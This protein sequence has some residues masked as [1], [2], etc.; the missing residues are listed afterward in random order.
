[1]TLL[2][3]TLCTVLGIDWKTGKENEIRGIGNARQLAYFHNI[4]MDVGGYIHNCYVGFVEDF[5][6][7]AL[8]GQKCFFHH[9]KKVSFDFNAGEVE[10]VW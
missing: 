4:Q 10:L 1:M 2:N 5:S 8:L 6:V 7:D 9:F 3:P